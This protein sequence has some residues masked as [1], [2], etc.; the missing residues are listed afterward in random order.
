M[1]AIEITN[2]AK[3]FNSFAAV[4]N[5]TFNVAQNRVLG[6]LGPNGA[7]KTTTIRMIVG[8]SRPTS[9]SIKIDNKE[10]KFADSSLNHLFGYLPEQPSFYSWMTGLEFLNFTADTFNIDKAIKN[11][12]IKELLKLVNLQE[13]AN[14]K[15]KTY[16]NGMKQRLGIAQAIINNPKVLIM[17]EPVSA[18]DPIG[19]REVLSIIENLKKEMTILFSTHILSDVDRICD[20]VVILNKGRLVINSSLSELKQTYATQILEIEFASDP[21]PIIKELKTEEWL[22][23]LEK[24]GNHLK[25]WMSDENAIIQNKP[26]KFLADQHISILKY[27]LVL[28]EV[29]DLF[30]DVLEGK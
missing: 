7:G 25:I 9:G 11:K 6:F 21:E 2:L 28:P 14:K 27:G 13:A 29:E 5:L 10:I 18:L 20:D 4:S 3:K 24:T 16:S 17:D 12:R 8:L 23:K 26:I 19:R 22:K 1:N 30:V 15:I